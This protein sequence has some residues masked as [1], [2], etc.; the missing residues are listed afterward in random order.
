MANR[1]ARTSA[2]SGLTFLPVIQA[3][4]QTVW[5]REGGVT[6]VAREQE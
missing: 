6:A 2:H 4:G 1:K 3:L 5:V